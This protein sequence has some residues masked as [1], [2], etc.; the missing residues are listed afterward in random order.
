MQNLTSKITS[1]CFLFS[2]FVVY[3]NEKSK[4]QVC[5]REDCP[6]IANTRG[7]CMTHS[8]HPCTVEGCSA[9]AYK[10]G[11]PCRTHGTYGHCS[12]RGCN[13]LRARRGLCTIHGA[14]GFCSTFDCD[15]HV[16]RGNFFSRPGSLFCF[17]VNP[18]RQSSFSASPSILPVNH[19]NALRLR[20]TGS[21]RAQLC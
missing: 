21:A 8:R 7:L 9:L 3:S 13:S 11:G 18:T 15:N 20:C 5:S 12:K 6:T 16:S 4:K 2:F 14:Y 1:T 10:V 19:P 17:P